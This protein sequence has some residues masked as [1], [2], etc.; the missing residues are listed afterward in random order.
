MIPRRRRGGRAAGL[1]VADPGRGELVALA[2]AL[3]VTAENVLHPVQR[4][5]VGCLGDQ[6][7]HAVADYNSA[8]AAG[9]LGCRVFPSVV[10]VV[11]WPMW[12]SS[13]LA[14]RSGFG[15]GT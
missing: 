12:D 4:L 15:V 9:D 6:G 14:Y 11:R 1:G 5:G 8:G 10:Q 13:C 7:E 2:E 3:Q